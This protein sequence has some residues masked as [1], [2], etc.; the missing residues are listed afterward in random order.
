[1]K[2]GIKNGWCQNQQEPELI[3]RDFLKKSIKLQINM[4]LTVLGFGTSLKG[5]YSLHSPEVHHHQ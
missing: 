1:M 4:I 3:V 2:E 5:Q